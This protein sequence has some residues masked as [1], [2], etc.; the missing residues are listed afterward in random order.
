[1][2]RRKRGK[3]LERTADVKGKPTTFKA[4]YPDNLQMHALDK[5]PAWTVVQTGKGPVAIRRE[6]DQGKGNDD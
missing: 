2:R 6:P 3:P 1:M 4:A 5:D